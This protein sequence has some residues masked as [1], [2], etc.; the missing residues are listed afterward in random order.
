[1]RLRAAA[2]VVGAVAMLVTAGPAT[3]QPLC[4]GEDNV[5]YVCVDPTGSS[6]TVCIYAGPPPCRPVTI[7]IP[8]WWCGG[9][10]ACP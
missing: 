2:A 8:T 10:I 1:M 5:A 4:V 6:K 3:A 9:V 7:P